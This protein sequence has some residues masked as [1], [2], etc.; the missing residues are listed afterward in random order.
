M[1]DRSEN[2]KTLELSS[3]TH[4]R[5][6]YEGKLLTLRCDKMVDSTSMI[7]EYDI[8]LHPGAVVMIPVNENGELYFVK[9]WRR[10]ASEIMLE[11]PA[12]VLEKGEQPLSCAS[13]ELQEE[14]GYK[15]DSLI[16]LGG[17]YTAPGFCNEYLH[18]FIAKD[19]SKSQLNAEDTDNIDIVTM[20]LKEALNAIEQQEIVDAKTICGIYRYQHWENKN[21]NE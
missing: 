7:H 12:G 18:L 1:S 14:I 4:S 15:P 9:Q 2:H 3:T 21:R 17:F 11:F 5:I 6:L 16:S 8:V 13:R 10:A 19:L 20:S